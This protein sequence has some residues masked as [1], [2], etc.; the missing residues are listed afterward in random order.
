LS[1]ILSR[2]PLRALMLDY[3]DLDI[4]L[5]CL[6]RIVKMRAGNIDARKLKE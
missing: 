1:D 2:Q 3:V 4:V 5:F 6:V